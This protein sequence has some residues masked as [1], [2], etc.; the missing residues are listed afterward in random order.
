MKEADGRIM[1]VLVREILICKVLQPTMEAL[2]EPDT[3]NMIFESGADK[4]I[5]QDP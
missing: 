2:S 1:R 5:D 3:W 4:L